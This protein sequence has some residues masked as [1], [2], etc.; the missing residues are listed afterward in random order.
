MEREAKDAIA[1]SIRGFKL[2]EYDTIP[3]VG[4]YLEQATK[5]ITG[6]LEPLEGVIITA[7][8]IS[9]YVKRGLVENPVKKQYSREQVAYLIFIA[10]AKT[11]LSLEDLQ[12]FIELQKKTYSTRTAYEYFCRELE[13]VLHHVFGLKE[14]LDEVGV[15]KTDEKIML[16]NTIITV[17][18]KI[19]LDKY[20]AVLREQS[21]KTERE[22]RKGKEPKE[23]ASKKQQ[24]G[25]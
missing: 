18:H 7:S 4:L 20:F 25:S 16:R 8:M 12:V 2:P 21:E 6:Y 1:A 3:D 23:K 24:G 17:A 13:N 5:Y 22:N 9:N 14:N 10:I 19:Y 15:E 11:V